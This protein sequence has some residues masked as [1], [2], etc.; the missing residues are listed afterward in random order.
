M[1][2]SAV[3]CQ[4]AWIAELSGTM[5]SEILALSSDE[6]DT[7][8]NCAPW[9]VRELAAHVVTGGEAFALSV[10]RGLAGSA[11]PGAPAEARRRRQEELSAADPATVAEALRTVTVE[12][13]DLYVGLA[14][15]QLDALCFHR[16]GERTVRWYA[17]HRLAEVAFHRWDLTFSTGR[18]PRLDEE[19]AG[20]LLPTLIESNAPSS[21]ADGLTPE[22]GSGERYVMAVDAFGPATRGASDLAAAWLVTINPT[23]LRVTAALGDGEADLTITGSAAA[24]ALLAYG[25]GQLR[26]QVEAGTLRLRGDS[27]LVDRFSA[28]FPKP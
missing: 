28:T 19:V 24:L 9:R 11:E 22:Q 14:D 1:T 18:D 4:L 27:T 7:V 10:R 13:V 16:R 8:T 15:A 6:W 20:L 23:E 25:R 17:A 5:S 2:D 3:P 21:Y 26:S 12:F